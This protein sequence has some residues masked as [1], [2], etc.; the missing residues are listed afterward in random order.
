MR[1]QTERRARRVAS[2]FRLLQKA[3]LLPPFPEGADP[4]DPLARHELINGVDE[5]LAGAIPGLIDPDAEHLSHSVF[6][7]RL[8]ALAIHQDLPPHAIGRAFLQ[9]AQ[10]RGFKSGRIEEASEGKQGNERQAEARKERS[11]VKAKLDRLPAEFERLGATTIGEYWSKLD[12]FEKRIR[13]LGNWSAR[14]M[15]VDEFERIWQRQAPGQPEIMTSGLRRILERKIYY[16]RPLKS[17]A[18]LI[19]HHSGGGGRPTAGWSVSKRRSPTIHSAT[20]TRR[21][22]RLARARADSGTRR[23]PDTLRVKS[24][25]GESAAW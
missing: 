23:R 5:Q 22:A 20:S 13:G 8:R 17:A 15:H 11:R 16:Q 3:G 12:P 6:H 4:A 7:Y 19:G 10:R 14:Q 21:S 2:A 24:T 25:T 1:R 18:G 9:I